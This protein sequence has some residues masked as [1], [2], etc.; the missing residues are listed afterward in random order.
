MELKTG[1]GAAFETLYHRYKEVLARNF[2]RLLRSEDL[3]QDALQDLFMNVWNA[4]LSID[5]SKSFRSYLF[6][7]AQHLV[8]DYYRKAATSERLQT[9]M[10]IVLDESYAHIEEALT[11]KEQLQLLHRVIDELP[12]ERRRVYVMHKIEGRAYKE[13]AELLSLSPT[14]ISKHIYHANQFIKSHPAIRSALL[15]A[16]CLASLS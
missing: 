10:L 12:E 6:Q 1:N 2:L 14:L 15:V 4:R 3:A 16:I 11:K 7:I 8:V 9:Q 13:I 5:P